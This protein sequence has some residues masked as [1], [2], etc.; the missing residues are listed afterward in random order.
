MQAQLDVLLRID[1][2]ADVAQVLITSSIIYIIHNFA[3]KQ[4]KTEVLLTGCLRRTHEQK[5]IML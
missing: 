2:P 5:I 3:Q 1:I 4:Q